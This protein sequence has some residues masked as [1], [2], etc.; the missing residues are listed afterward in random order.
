MN[1]IR[2][3]RIFDILDFDDLLVLFVDYFLDLGLHVFF[4]FLEELVFAFFNICAMLS[5][6]LD[7]LMNLLDGIGIVLP[8]LLALLGSLFL[9]IRD[10]EI[11]ILHFFFHLL[12]VCLMLLDLTLLILNDLP[13]V[14][15]VCLIG[16]DHLRENF[17]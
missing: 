11:H 15:S 6:I 13:Q 2:L 4:G 5:Q 12:K 14:A 8:G 10:L 17:P 9:K 7:P 3:S 1:L 16:L